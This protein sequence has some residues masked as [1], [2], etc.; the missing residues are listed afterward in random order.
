VIARLAV[1]VVLAVAVATAEVVALT[2]SRLVTLGGALT[3]MLRHRV[4]KVVLVAAW[5]WLGW[6]IF[7]RR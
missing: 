2:T 1:W 6:H 4:L 7:V 5:L 3:S